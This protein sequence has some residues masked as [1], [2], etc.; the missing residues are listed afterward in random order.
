MAE[1]TFSVLRDQA[2]QLGLEG[3]DIANYVQGQQTLARDERIRQREH[4]REL[5][6]FE[7]AKEQLRLEAELERIKIE[8]EEKIGLEKL[9]VENEQKLRLAE[10]EAEQETVRLEAERQ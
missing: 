7:K 1:F 4:E 2:I 10:I 6:A 3:A 8:S 5:A 9:K